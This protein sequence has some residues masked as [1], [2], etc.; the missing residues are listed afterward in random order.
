MGIPTTF[1]LIESYFK[2]TP[3]RKKL[4]H[5][6]GKSVAIDASIYMWKFKLGE[7]IHQFI[8][9]IN[10]LLKYE[11]VPIFVIDGRPSPL[12]KKEIEKRKKRTLEILEKIKLLEESGCSADELR[13]LKINSRIVTSDD[14]K[15]LE[16]ILNYY[17]IAWTRV[18]GREA[19]GYCSYLNREGLVDY[20]ISEDTDVFL[21]GAN[22]WIRYINQNDIVIYNLKKLRGQFIRASTHHPDPLVTCI[23]FGT[24]FS[25]PVFD[26]GQFAEV[27]GTQLSDEYQVPEEI[28]DEYTSDNY[29]N[30]ILTTVPQIVP[31]PDLEGI[32]RIFPEDIRNKLPRR[33]FLV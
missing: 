19:E 12:K 18:H 25:D 22:L 13:I 28:L 30:V 17:G 15:L 2:Y 3:S 10:N 32:A 23:L 7:G 29:H 33:C 16:D 1:K 21:Y 31:I 26:P 14:W 4:S 11:I 8:S 6:R 5:I 20:V 9:F 24:D 27:L